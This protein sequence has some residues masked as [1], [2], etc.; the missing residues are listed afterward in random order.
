MITPH[1]IENELEEVPYS[2]LDRSN[3]QV[4]VILDLQYPDT[5]REAENMF[6]C[7]EYWLSKG[8][9]AQTGWSPL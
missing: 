8:L 7:A 5:K 4:N 9:Q 6:E 3:L 2:E 1:E